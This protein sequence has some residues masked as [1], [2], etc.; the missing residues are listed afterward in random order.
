MYHQPLSRIPAGKKHCC[1]PH[2][3]LYTIQHRIWKRIQSKN[4]QNCIQ[5]TCDLLAAFHLCIPGLGRL[6]CHQDSSGNHHLQFRCLSCRR[7]NP[8]PPFCCF[9]PP[10]EVIFFHFC[11]SWA[12]AP[13]STKRCGKTLES[14]SHE[15]SINT[16]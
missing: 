8:P 7:A 14:P 6:E 1:S 5:V 4:V 12:K 2:D 15:T 3:P 10:A 9:P 11:V 13:W 16:H